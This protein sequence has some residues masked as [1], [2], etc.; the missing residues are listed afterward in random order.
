[1]ARY[2]HSAIAGW[3][4]PLISAIENR[5]GLKIA[6]I[7]EVAW[8]NGWITDSDFCSTGEQ[9]KNSEYGQYIL[10]LIG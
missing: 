9:L 3:R 7:E 5:Q 2:W 10:R 4:R 6:C 8:R 1:M